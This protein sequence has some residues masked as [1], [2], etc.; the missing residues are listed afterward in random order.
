MYKLYQYNDNDFRIV[1]T[2]D[3]NETI[4]KNKKD[5][6]FI[7]QTESEEVE[8]ISLSRAKRKI[9]EYGLCNNFKYFFTCTV[10]S[11]NCDRFSLTETQNKMRTIMKAI[12]RKNK[13]FIYLFI[14]EKHKDGA[15]HFH[16]LCSDLTLYINNNGYFSSAD[17]DK[18]GFNSFSAIKDVSKCSNYITKYIT[19]E[20]IKN[21]AGSVYFCSKGLK[22]AYSYPICPIDFNKL[23]FALSSDKKATY[24][25]NDYCKVIDYRLNDL[26]SEQLLFISNYIKELPTITELLFNKFKKYKEI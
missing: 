26:N 18:L 14:T 11:K 5:D 2:F 19:K 9:R 21:E 6:E 3:K 15:F 13:E 8:R 10:S 16:G 25:K 17:F 22:T 7:K 1:C 24:F 4:Y 23:F 20:C 12:K